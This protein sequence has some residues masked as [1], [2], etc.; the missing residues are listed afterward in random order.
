MAARAQL[1]LRLSS[2][3]M[4][5]CVGFGIGSA[6]YKGAR[7]SEPLRAAIRAA[8][9]AG[10]RHIDD[11]EMY[12]NEVD[13]G[14]ALR[15]WLTTSGV[16][17]SELFVTSKV[18][19]SI[20]AGESVDVACRRT[21]HNLGLEYIDL[22]LL[23]APFRRADAGPL[24]LPLPTLWAAME[25][26]VH[27]GLVRSIG[28]SNFRPCDLA[29]IFAARPAIPPAI[30]QVERHPRLRQPLLTA[31]CAADRIT[32]AAYG[33]LVPLTRPG[34]GSDSVAAIAAA[35]AAAR[36]GGVTPARV[37]L[38]WALRAPGASHGSAV[39]VTTTSSPE[40][41]AD[42]LAAGSLELTDAEVGALDAAGAAVASLRAYW[43][44][45]KVDWGG[46]AA[47]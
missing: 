2:G 47:M 16:P 22:Y 27:A 34:P 19:A 45:L 7:G 31:A 1:S 5:P 37:L 25:A 23:H 29:E 38:A 24:P 13:V 12:S 30:N 6:W 20:E 42:A 9:D 26:L 17:R 28:V 3:H 32:L 33:P 18:L 46:G 21:L 11:A 14:E 35:I 44:S 40:R 39:V 4:M 41:M 10:F 43:G 36:G 15:D 8:L